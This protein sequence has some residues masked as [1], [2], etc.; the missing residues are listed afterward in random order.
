MARRYIPNRGDVV[1]VSFNPQAGHEQAG[2]R[3]ALVVSPASYNGKVGL[4]IFCPVTSQ[5]KGYPFEVN[6]P[7]GSQIDGVVLS[8]Q[9]KSLDWR[10]RGAEFI[11]KLPQVIILEVLDR[12]AVLLSPGRP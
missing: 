12:I 1:W 8:D 11:C 10:A 3:P 9:V 7:P 4:A 2:R 5:V 6:V